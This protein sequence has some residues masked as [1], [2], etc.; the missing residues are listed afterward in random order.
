MSGVEENKILTDFELNQKEVGNAVHEYIKASSDFYQAAGM[1]LSY[2]PADNPIEIIGDGVPM[3]VAY[4][5]NYGLTRDQLKEAKEIMMKEIEEESQDDQMLIALDAEPSQYEELDEKGAWR[6]FLTNFPAAGYAMLFP[7][8]LELLRQRFEFWQSKLPREI[9]E[10]LFIRDLGL[11]EAFDANINVIEHSSSG[12]RGTTWEVL[13]VKVLGP[14][15][16]KPK[17]SEATIQPAVYVRTSYVQLWDK[18]LERLR[19][20]KN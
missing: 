5:N 8:Q 18:T 15:I 19:Q 14:E 12:E 1:Q 4:I 2:T 6:D 16:V 20:K 9:G 3:H 13:L 10:K 11:A 17:S 7:D